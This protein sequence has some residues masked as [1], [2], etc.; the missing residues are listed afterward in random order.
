[1]SLSRSTLTPVAS[2]SRNALKSS[3]SVPPPVSFSTSVPRESAV[4]SRENT[5]TSS[6]APPTSE[7]SPLPPSRVSAP[8]RPEIVSFPSRVGAQ[9]GPYLP[10]TL[11]GYELSD[12]ETDEGEPVAVKDWSDDDT[13][14]GDDD[15]F[16]P[17]VHRII[18]TS[19]EVESEDGL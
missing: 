9:R 2:A 4:A 8:A 14:P 6:F 13:E 10:G 11:L 17:V 3:V 1:M 12:E 15:A 19:E 18:N 7:S 16:T 5:Y